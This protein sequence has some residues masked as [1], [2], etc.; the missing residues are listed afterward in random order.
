MHVNCLRF[1]VFYNENGDMDL[2]GLLWNLIHADF[3][4]ILVINILE[5]PTLGQ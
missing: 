2:N 5:L 3:T 4:R 1:L